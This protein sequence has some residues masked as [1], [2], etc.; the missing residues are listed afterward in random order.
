MKEAKLWLQVF[1]AGFA[2]NIAALVAMLCTPIP[3]GDLSRIGRFSEHEFGWLQEP[4]HV[5]RQYLQASPMSEADILVI[6]DSFSMTFRWQSVL[7]RAGYRFTTIYWGDLNEMLCDDFD[8]WLDRAGFRGQLVLIESVE[9]LLVRRMSNTL[10]CKTTRD[11]PQFKTEPSVENPDH[12]PEFELNKTA[13]VSTALFTYYNTHA[14][15]KSGPVRAGNVWARPVPDGCAMFSHRLCGKALFLKQDDDNGELGA[16]QVEQMRVF[17]E[18]HPTRPIVWMVIPNKTTVYVRTDHSKDFTA[19]LA[20]AGLGPDLF[21]FAQAQKT[22]VQDFYFPNDT[23]LSMHGQLALGE[24]M[25]GIV[26][27]MIPA[28]AAMPS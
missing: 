15:K 25:L 5:E 24:F 14:A 28:P 18:A 21:A 17:S 19:A 8:V 6:G 9:R 1:M 26:R 13:K 11:P 7:K 3:Y 22:R 4:P 10:Q 20:Q 27:K 12:V 2:L 23:H 16:L